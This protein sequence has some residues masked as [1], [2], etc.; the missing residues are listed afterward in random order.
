MNSGARFS[1]LGIGNG[2]EW[3]GSRGGCTANCPP[4][5]VC[6]CVCARVGASMLT[7]HSSDVEMRGCFPE[8]GL[9]YYVV[10]RN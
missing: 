9:S 6:V 5:L 8:S 1:E 2:E 4:L 7:R 10:P 3:R